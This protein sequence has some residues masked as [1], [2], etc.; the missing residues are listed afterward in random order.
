MHALMS[1]A[2][3]EGPFILEF[4]AHHLVLGFDRIMIASNDCS[5]GSDA[6]LAALHGA[7]FIQHLHQTVAPHEVPQHAGYSKLRAAF[8]LDGVD[9]LMV[10]D[11]DE[12][13]HVSIGDG[14]V[15]DLTAAAPVQVDI[16]ALNA[17]SFGTIAGA[18]WQPERV[19]ERFTR[20][21]GSRDKLNGMVKSITRAPQRFGA[22]YNHHPDHFHPAAPL[23]VMRADG[24]LWHTDLAKPLWKQLRH[25]KPL[26]IRHDWASFH[27]YAIKTYDSF[28]LRRARGN[29]AIVASQKH[30]ERYSD[31]YFKDFSR[32]NIADMSI[33][34][35]KEQVVEMMLNMLSVPA[36]HDAQKR[37]ETLTRAK[38]AA[39][40]NPTAPAPD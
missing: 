8:G 28:A 18:Q 12:F 7:G 3:D 34:K 4:V 31:A 16:I 11:V 40:G 38:L 20:R 30:A 39:L 9:W 25:F 1:C 17:K 21:L 15:Q 14:R 36:I 37:T 26:D 13:L 2:K 35:Y 5:D 33:A 19:C 10:L 32:A 27:H 6:L 23:S 22:I 29:G 24:A